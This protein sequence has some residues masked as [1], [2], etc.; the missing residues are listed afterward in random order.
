MGRFHVKKKSQIIVALLLLWPLLV[1]FPMTAKTPSSDS[2]ASLKPFLQRYFAGKDENKTVRYIVAFHDL[3]GDGRPEAI[4]Y[5]TGPE[6]CGSGGCKLYVLTPTGDSWM[7]VA[8]TTITWPPIRV[9]DA[10]S[11]GWH[12][13]AVSVGGGGI[14]AGYEAELRFDGKKYPGNPSAPPARRA[15]KNLAGEVVIKDGDKPKPLW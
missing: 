1:S 11:H 2:E 5:I 3:N 4:V 15:A 13:L 12:N 7:I 6:W 10:T 9:L 8:K 14:Q